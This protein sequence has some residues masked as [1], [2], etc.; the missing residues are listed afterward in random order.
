MSTF[1]EWSLYCLVSHPEAQERAAAQVAERIGSSRA[2]SLQDEESVPYV[3][4]LV[5]EVARHAPM[6]NFTLPHSNSRDAV[7]GKYFF[8]KGTQVCPARP[9]TRFLFHALTLHP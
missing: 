9:K 5:Q 1:L 8:P 2:V 3:S 6:V 4:A 7:A